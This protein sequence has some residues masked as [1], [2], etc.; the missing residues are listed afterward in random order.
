MVSESSTGCQPRL[1]HENLGTLMKGDKPVAFA[2]IE[3]LYHAALTLGGGDQAPAHGAK[4]R[5]QRA[6]SLLF[7]GPKEVDTARCATLQEIT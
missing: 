4:G 6:R 3:P 5:R 7:D 1:M 2:V